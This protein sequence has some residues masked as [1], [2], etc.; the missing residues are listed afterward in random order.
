MLK[1][2][3]KY[4]RKKFSFNISKRNVKLWAVGSNEELRFVEWN[5]D[6]GEPWPDENDAVLL[7]YGE[8]WN[9]P[10]EHVNNIKAKVE[11]NDVVD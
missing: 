4:K 10:F 11:Y 7:Y 9:G 6:E 5:L 3:G 2:K 1:L 8:F